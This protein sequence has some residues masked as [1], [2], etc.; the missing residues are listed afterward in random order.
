MSSGVDIAAIRQAVAA[1]LTTIP[2]LN[3]TAYQMSTPDLPT[4]H[5]SR[6]PFTY[7]QALQGG[8]HNLTLTITAYV[9][10]VSAEGAQM[11]LD[12]YLAADGEF[13][14]KE[15]VEADTTLGGLVQDLHVTGATGETSYAREQGGPVLGSDWTDRKSV[16]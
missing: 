10:L 6:G 3:A 5:V 11:L 13:S 2:G 9:A 12:R 14:V 8:V 15:A 4:A 1:A 16:V 7:D